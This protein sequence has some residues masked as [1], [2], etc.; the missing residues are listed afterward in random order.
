MPYFGMPSPRIQ[1]SAAPPESRLPAPSFPVLRVAALL[2]L[3]LNCVYLFTSTGRVRTI[4]E[5]DPV[6][7]SESLL[8]RHSTAIPQAVRSGI[9][10]GKSDRN[11]LP[12][13]AWP[14]GHPLLV[15]P[16]T[17]VGHYALAKLPGI[18]P[19]KA[20]LAISAATCWSSATFAAL[21]VAISFLLFLELG[22]GPQS[23]LA[24][25]LLLAFSTPLFVYS[26][27]LYSEPATTAIFM[28]AALLLFGSGKPAPFSRALPAS[29][30]LAF[31]MHVRPVNTVTVLVFVAAALVLDLS[32]DRPGFRFR[33]TAILLALA[34]IAGGLYL[35]RNQALF[36]QPFDFGVPPTAENGKDLDSWHNPVWMGVFGYLFSPGKSAFL[37]SPP[38]ILG[39]LGLSRLWRR[40]RP[41]ALLCGAVPLVNLLLFSLRTQWE[42]GYSY[43]PRYLVPSLTLLT[44]P[45]AALFQEP[46]RWLR[47]AFWI[48]AI[49][50]FLVQAIGLSTNIMEDMVRNHYYVGNWDYRMSYS[51]LTGQIRLIW[52]YLHVSS[53]RLGLG[54]DRWFVFLRAAGADPGPLIA[55]ASLFLLSGLI[56]GSLTWLSARNAT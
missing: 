36:G 11:G 2:F 52:K 31:S 19:E 14:A 5:V 48:T 13:S 56:F 35:A 3:F 26:G 45:I 54:W 50:G 55:I 9:W 22:L 23:A 29:L 20:D 32:S 49:L 53:P 30:L 34:A 47:P 16:W 8:L 4:D 46:P 28:L 37:F 15:L 12:R 18:T 33:T 43:G 40:N 21:A 39:I 24:C 51:P 27:W 10:F 6:M 25:S 1:G 17:A 42:G 7:Q 44:L 41:L 38:I